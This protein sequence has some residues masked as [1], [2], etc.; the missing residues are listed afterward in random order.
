[1]TRRIRKI[2]FTAFLT[3]TA[4]TAWSAE[5]LPQPTTSA[6]SS[7]PAPHKIWYC[8]EGLERFFPGDYYACRAAYHLQRKH[9]WQFLEM[10]KEAA[11]WANKNAQYE[12]G[13][14][15]FN[16]NI[17]G[18]PKNRPLGIAWLALAAERKNPTFQKTY[19]Q[20]CLQSSPGEIREAA[21]L[22]KKLRPEYSDKTAG[23]RAIRRYNRAIQP[24]ALAAGGGGIVY[25]RGFSDFPEPAMLVVKKLQDIADKDFADLQGTVTVGALHPLHDPKP[26]RTDNPN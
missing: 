20:A 18:V 12:L 10:T 2:L 23:L 11:H 21:R 9:Y 25:I 19:T 16:G 7:K 4:M 22:W 6:A 17:P 13:L 24:F 1:M 8:L 26:A 3:G 5:A 15:Y 14:V